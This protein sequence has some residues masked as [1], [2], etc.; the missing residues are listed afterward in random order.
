MEASS[1]RLRMDFSVAFLGGHVMINI[2]YLCKEKKCG[3]KNKTRNT[4]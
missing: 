2:E 3:E 1:I 4:N